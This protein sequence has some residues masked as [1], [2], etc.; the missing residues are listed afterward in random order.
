MI[1]FG[2]SIFKLLRMEMGGCEDGGVVGFEGAGGE[3]NGNASAS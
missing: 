1:I 3:M 2:A